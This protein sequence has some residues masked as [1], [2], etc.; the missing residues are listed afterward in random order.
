MEPFKNEDPE[1]ILKVAGDA[2][3]VQIRDHEGS[4]YHKRGL[5][6]NSKYKWSIQKDNLGASYVLVAEKPVV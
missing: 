3:A 4:L 5:Y 1:I 6:L 2:L